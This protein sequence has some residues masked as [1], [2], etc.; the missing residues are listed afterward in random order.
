M[1]TPGDAIAAGRGADIIAIKVF[2]RVGGVQCKYDAEAPSEL[3]FESD[4]IAGLEH[5]FRLHNNFAIGAASLSLGT[6]LFTLGCND[7][8]LKLAVD[9]LRSVGIATLIPSGNGGLRD[10][11]EAPGCISSAMTVPEGDK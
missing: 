9:N 3:S 1:V 11:A 7:N 10:A 5:V 8:P 2:T 4:N 6:G